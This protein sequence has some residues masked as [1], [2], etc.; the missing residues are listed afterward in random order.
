MHGRHDPPEKSLMPAH[1]QILTTLPPGHV[2]APVGF[3]MG[4]RGG[5]YHLT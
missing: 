3:L 1:R 5:P 2:P 4:L